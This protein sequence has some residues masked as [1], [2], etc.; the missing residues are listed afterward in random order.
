MII[1][2]VMRM[3]KEK[4]NI[5]IAFFF[6]IFSADISLFQRSLNCFLNL[7]PENDAK[8]I[9]S[10]CIFQEDVKLMSDTSLEAYR[11]SISW[12]RLIPSKKNVLLITIDLGNLIIISLQNM[13]PS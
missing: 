6:A 13:C 11:F 7:W 9:G 8:L 12:S 2:K 3:G 10:I 4:S 1:K 5:L